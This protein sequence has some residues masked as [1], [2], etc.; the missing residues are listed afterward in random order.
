MSYTIATRP[1][2]PAAEA[3]QCADNGPSAAANY[4]ALLDAGFFNQLIRETMGGTRRQ[5][6]ALLVGG[7]ETIMNLMI[8]G[9]CL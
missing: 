6:M 7:D 4:H 8:L 9:N 1:F 3:E 2:R 5:I